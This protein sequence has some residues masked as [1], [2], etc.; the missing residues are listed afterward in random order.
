MSGHEDTGSDAKPE[1]GPARVTPFGTPSP[2]HRE[3]PIIEGE[4]IHAESGSEKLTAAT[5][6][7]PANAA[8]PLAE[9]KLAMEELLA[10]DQELADREAAESAKAAPSEAG[11]PPQAVEPPSPPRHGLSFLAVILAALIGA[12]TGFASAYLA[13]LFLDDSQKTF[14][15]LDQRITAMNMKLD[16]DQK[17]TDA[18]SAGNRDALSSLEKRLGAAEKSASDALSRATA[19]QTA[20]Q[21]AG[22]SDTGSNT[23]AAP[24]DL[25]PLQS[26][27][28]ALEQRLSGLEAAVNAPKTAV[29][30]P[31]EPEAKLNPQ[32]A[33]A[34]AIAIVA[35]NLSQKI[36][37]G[38]PFTT[39][40]A[41]LD[42]LGAD[43][44][45]LAALQPAAG[46]GI[47]TAK[48]LLD[49]F[50]A[51]TPGLLAG[52]KPAAQGNVFERLMSHAAGLV[53]IRKV[54]DLSGDD[55]HA[56]V[57][58]VQD[59][60]AHDD[61]DRALQEWA[62]FPEA[63]KTASANWAEAAKARAG[64]SAAAKAIAADAMANLAK[65]KS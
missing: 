39:E 36:A 45:K 25:A 29:R 28:D 49:Q 3:K 10:G 47:F 35:E 44:T 15:A 48:A 60:L 13:R 6:E 57:A 14:A 5:P 19:A 26:R 30:A 22:P 31:Q 4:A 17:K 59:A 51:L 16:A 52:D 53:R 20:A 18:A 33:N 63:A 27:I 9:V 40:L 62:T 43:K 37:S 8:E 38:A 32:D 1:P 12:A 42:R 41:A 50:N 54:G 11:V 65:V 56:H 34:P 58:R 24:V 2:L 7:N 55:M 64:A 23:T 46:K 21:K 61:V